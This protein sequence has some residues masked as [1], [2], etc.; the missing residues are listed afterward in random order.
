MSHP[1]ASLSRATPVLVQGASGRMGRRHMLLM[2]DYGTRIVAGTSAR[3]A[4]GSIEGI[5]LFAGCAEAV[6]ATG[7]TASVCMVPPLEVLAAA[8][9]AIAAGIRLV[10]T[11]AEGVPVHD[12]VRLRAL[13]RARGATW[14]GA[15]TPGCA[16]PGRVKLGFLP[17]VA[18]RPGPVALLTKSGTL[19][20]E[21]GYRLAGIG[22]GQSL[23]IGVGGDAVKGTRF[24]ELLPVLVASA[25]TEAVVL[26]GEVGGTE[27]EEF[28]AALSRAPLGRPVLALLAGREAKEGVAMGHAG[29]LTYGDMGSLASKT[30]SLAA[31]GVEVSGSMQALVDRCAGLLGRRG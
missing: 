5:P 28:A 30:A 15:S 4:G 16:I 10:V 3:E 21:V 13:A 23:W 17:D 2:R 25:A 7:A 6:A 14:L 26:I 11:I 1:L 24:A 19:S 18:L 31:A 8:T 9:E 27:E 12:A 20:Y 29:A 22:L